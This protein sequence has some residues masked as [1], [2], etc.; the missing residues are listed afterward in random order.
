MCAISCGLIGVYI[1]VFGCS[2]YT[3]T[4]PDSQISREIPSR[5]VRYAF[6]DT[7]W[8]GWVKTVPTATQSMMLVFNSPPSFEAWTQCIAR[9]PLHLDYNLVGAT[10][11]NIALTKRYHQQVHSELALNQFNCE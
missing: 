9:L 3:P 8:Q 6:K 10:I 11:D 4:L 7:T 1:F 5:Q 2:P